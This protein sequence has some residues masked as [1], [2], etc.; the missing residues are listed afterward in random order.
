MKTFNGLLLTAF[1][2]ICM[3]GFSSCSDDIRETEGTGGE[4]ENVDMDIPIS[5]D[6]ENNTV[7]V[8]YINKEAT[9]VAAA[10]IKDYV[11]ATVEGAQVSL[12]Q[13]SEVDETIGEITYMLQGSSTDGSFALEGSYKATVMLNGLDLAN[14]SGA[15][16][17]IQNGKRIKLKVADGTVNRLADGAD[18]KQKA[19]LYCKGHLEFSGTGSL[20]VTGNTAHAISAKEYIEIKKCEIIVL[21]AIKDGFN[22]NQ[23]F[24]MESGT[25]NISGTGDDGIQVSYKDDADREEEDTGNLTIEGGTLIVSVTAD[26]AKALKADNDIV[27]TNGTVEAKVSGNGIWDEAKS[28]TKASA[29]L[30]ADHNVEISGGTLT[31]TAM[32]SGG[33]GINCDNEFN[34][35][36]GKVTL[37]TSGGMVVYTNGK[38][39][40]NYTGNTDRIDSDKK[41]SPKGV[42]ADGNITITGGDIYVKTTGNGGEGIES[43]SDLTIENGNITIRAKDDGI[44][45]SGNMY[46]KGGYIDVMSSDNDGLDANK[47]IYISGGTIMAF[48]AGSPECGIDA[49][50]E[51]GYT[52]YFTGGN[53]L[54]AGGRNSTPK[55]N[56]STQPYVSTN[57]SLTAGEKVN[58]LKESQELFTFDIPSDY[59]IGNTGG[60]PGGWG[61]GG[62]NKST[63][64]LISVQGMVSGESY[65]V[66]SGSSST[67]VTAR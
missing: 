21:K 48:G 56:N 67:T 18:G 62:N 57:F 46:I 58:V 17:D 9:V 51:E 47:N 14:T 33:K 13:S 40:H 54:A 6:L 44:N 52:V 31:L 49:N 16:I 66:K 11:S 19:S 39:N 36:G 43:K 63:S 53:L 10:N 61:P 29:C 65:T 32:G 37:S 15:A 30:G 20:R 55:N 4:K 28:K 12:V 1:S 60:A 64:V 42:K 27:V 35:S 22:C 25:V 24:L 59:T 34:L 8:Y 7:A 3:L 41:S 5:D 38:L 23:Y 45:S 50:E 26:A 2:L